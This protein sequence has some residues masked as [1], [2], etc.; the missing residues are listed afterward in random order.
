MI[1][2]SSWAFGNRKLIHFLIAVLV[3]GGLYAAYDMSKFE[4]PEIKVKQALVVTAFPGASASQVEFQVTDPLEKEIR[5]MPDVF[6]LESYSYND[7]SIIRVELLSTV[8]SGEV[9]QHWDFLRRKV[10]NALHSLPEGCNQPN[11]MDDFSSVSGMFLALSGDGM[12]DAELGRWAE[13]TKREL[14]AIP[15]VDCIDIYGERRECINIELRQNVMASLGVKPAEI[16]ATL[17]NQNSTTYSG[18]FDQGSHRIRI[19]TDGKLAD[20]QSIRD[21]LLQG[22]EGDQLRVKDIAMVEKGY[23]DP[24][25]N[26]LLYD[27]ERSVGILI[28]T[29]SNSDVVKVGKAV[30]N[31][32]EELRQTRYPAGIEVHK[33]FFQPE[34]VT[35]A[36]GTFFINLIESVAIVI[37]I[38]MLAMGFRSG[39]I[40]A[41]SLV[42]IVLGSLLFL[43]G[44]NGT[45]Q[46]VSL[47]SFILAM[48]MLVD[49]AI[50][51]IDGILVDLRRG[52][53]M[54]EAL[55]GIGGRTAMPLLGATLI[56]ILA[57]LPIFLSPDTTGL[58]VRDLFIVLAVSLLLSWIL[59]L[60]HVP[61]LGERMAKKELARK[62]R[63]GE[64]DG[65]LFKG[66]A[67]D[68]LGGI[69]EWALSHR[70][71]TI[72]GMVVLLALTLYGYGYM[73]QG[74]FPDMSYN[75]LYIEYKLPEST[76]NPKV[77]KDL[78]DIGAWLRK[79]PQITH[80]TTSLGGSPG[81]YNLVRNV[82]TPSLSYGELIVDF[83]SPKDL[84]KLYPALQDSLSVKYPD[85]YLKVKKYNL[86]YRKYPIEAQIT[87][88]DLALLEN[89]ADTVR[90]IMEST[91]K[92]CCITRDLEPQVPVLRIGY[93]QAAA[94][95][96]GLSRK[97]VSLSLMAANG[98]IPVGNFYEG[99]NPQHI[100]VKLVDGITGGPVEDLED[101]PVFATLPNVSSVLDNTTINRIINRTI[102]NDE[103]VTRVMATTP[104]RQ[105]ID[106]I[107][108]D[109]EY[110]VIPRYDG[111]RMV[112]VQASPAYGLETERTRQE[113]AAKVEKLNL[114]TGYSLSWQG[115]KNASDESMKYLFK[116][117]PLAI[118]LMIF[119]LI[120]LFKDYRRPIII[121]CTIPCCMIGVVATMLVTRQAFTFCAIVGALGLIGMVIKN[122]IVLMD[123]I[124]LQIESG[125]PRKEALVRSAKSRLLPVSMAALTTIFGMVPLLSDAMFGSMAAA[126]MGGLTFG[127]V[128]TL[129]FVPVLYS[130]FFKDNE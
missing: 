11:V 126:I 29:T 22:H 27:G 77:S 72:C 116:M 113:I 121:F 50:V 67:Y 56:A 104:L 85:A 24:T 102:S 52:I 81:R 123:E 129:V 114:P 111:Q 66:K 79:F 60:V 40:I 13:M 45:M 78:E 20:V 15:G 44:M 100:Y 90:N 33:V 69:L 59:A 51:I 8:P 12:G 4:D 28:T 118:I 109:W 124:T 58:Y 7:V 128:V 41:V 46:R 76:D 125:L 3:V 37:V 32:L 91:G 71:V 47:A 98:G 101:I 99:L 5:K 88:P 49:N 63:S 74:F 103:L 86:M 30:L 95:R 18:Y 9:E 62:K 127:T 61:L 115:E 14:L 36:L 87:G 42:T 106:G 89:Y 19:S 57:F 34:K 6:H 122:G 108:V 117:F 39:M 107:R 110:P 83:K 35:E 38:L 130:I 96:M 43:Y 120:L 93:N 65:E 17:K 112:R 1:N 55:T 73:R 25:R 68:I 105:V 21:M 2:L 94:L 54:H 16:L 119:I 82:A 84:N 80:V 75:Q 10:A 31:K 23:E 26:E 64:N 70:T 48:G 92:V 53:P 97:D